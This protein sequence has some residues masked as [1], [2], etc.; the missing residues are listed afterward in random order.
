MQDR[1]K[2]PFVYEKVTAVELLVRVSNGLCERASTAFTFASA[3]SDQIYLVLR[4]ASSLEM[5]DGEKRT[6]LK[7]SDSRIKH[8]VTSNSKR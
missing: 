4:I 7:F 1:L 2:C 8:D 5:T 6:V 3:S